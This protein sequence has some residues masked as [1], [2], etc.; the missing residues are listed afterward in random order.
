MA[1]YDTM[2]EHF[3][4]GSPSVERFLQHDGVG[5]SNLAFHMEVLHIGRVVSRSW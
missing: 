2:V 1:A 3:L 4:S 5:A